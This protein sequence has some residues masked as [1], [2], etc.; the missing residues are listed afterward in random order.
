MNIIRELRLKRGWSQEDLAEMAGLSVR[1]IQRLEN[2]GRASLETLK[3]LAAVF[4]SNVSQ[5]REDMNMTAT[6]TTQATGDTPHADNTGKAA[7]SG[8]HGCLS[9]EDRAALQFARQLRAYA[10]LESDD[11]PAEL[12][13]RRQVK[14]ERGFYVHAGV[15]VA[16]MVLLAVVDVLATPGRFW[17]QWPLLGWGAGLLWHG[18]AV[19]G[20]KAPFGTDW[21][22]RQVERR[23]SR[24]N[25][26]VRNENARGENEGKNG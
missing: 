3:C 14:R 22:R 23:L 21:E 19:F 13:V 6:M 5:L 25:A 11:L 7:A 1:T 10:E 24:L 8:T 12:A 9:P 4:E 18:L 2:G 26:D 15:F 20:G 16:V 17:V